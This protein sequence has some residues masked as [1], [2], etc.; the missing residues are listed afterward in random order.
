VTCYQCS[1]AFFN[2]PNQTDKG[3][4]DPDNW[5]QRTF[6]NATFESAVQVQLVVNRD[7]H[8]DFNKS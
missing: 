4:G 5:L 7:N 6:F 3:F 2:D 8:G 1:S